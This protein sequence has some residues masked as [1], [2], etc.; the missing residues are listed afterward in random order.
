MKHRPLTPEELA[1]AMRDYP[2][3]LGGPRS[4]GAL[5]AIFVAITLSVAVFAALAHVDPIGKVAAC[6]AQLEALQ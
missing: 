5:L 6:A 4:A 2:R 1:E 3:P